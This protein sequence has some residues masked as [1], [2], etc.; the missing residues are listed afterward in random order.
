MKTRLPSLI[1][2]IALGGLL[3]ACNDVSAPTVD[4]RAASFAKG[5]AGG[6]GGGAAGGGGGGATAAVNLNGTW[7]GSITVATNNCVSGC[8]SGV[9]PL[10]LTI[11]EDASLNVSGDAPFNRGP[12]TGTAKADGSFSGRTTEGF[13]VTA[14][15]TARVCA[16]GSAGTA[17]TGSMRFNVLG[18]NSFSG[19]F[20]VDNCP[21]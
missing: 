4:Q 9:K 12:W 10:Q 19:D 16:D 2:I 7:N 20:D 17:L 1:G 11:A 14:K 21:A 8:F 5:V 3:A 15:A 6:G 13:S 18:G